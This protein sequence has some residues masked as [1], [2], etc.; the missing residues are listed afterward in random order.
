LATP[1]EDQSAEDGCQEMDLWAR[2]PGNP[3]ERGCDEQAAKHAGKHAIFLR[4]FAVM[5][6]GWKMGRAQSV[7]ETR[8]KGGEKRADNGCRESDADLL[9]RE[10]IGRF[11]HNRDGDEELEDD[12]E[13]KPNVETESYNDGLSD[14]HLYG[15]NDGHNDHV[16][17]GHAALR[18]HEAMRSTVRPGSA[19]E[20]F[21]S[22]GVWH[23][24]CEE[25]RAG[26][27]DQGDP[28]GPGPAN[29]SEDEA[30]DEGT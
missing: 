25:Q 5:V 21:S 11:Q 6:S 24:N 28:L 10:V 27:Q 13:D 4:H 23:A 9:D 17:E 2:G 16:L 1:D 26:G 19:S 12:R 30:G 20:D 29:L 18:R 15:G 14:E 22:I 7:H 8:S 3:E